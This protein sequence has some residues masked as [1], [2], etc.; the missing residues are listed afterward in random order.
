MAMGV[1]PVQPHTPA[2]FATFLGE[3]IARWGQVI[4]D[5][6]IVIE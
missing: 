1:N 4:K 3:E 2:Q 6:N 5:A